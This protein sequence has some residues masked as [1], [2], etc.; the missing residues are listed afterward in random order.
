[1]TEN[2]K[3]EAGYLY[4]PSPEMEA[5]RFKIQDAIGRFDVEYLMTI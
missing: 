4:R 1:M 3:Q 2:E 5:H